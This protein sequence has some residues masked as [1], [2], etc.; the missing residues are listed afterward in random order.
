MPSDKVL[1][2]SGQELD[3]MICQKRVVFEMVIDLVQFASDEVSLER[4]RDWIELGDAV[5]FADVLRVKD[6]VVELGFA[7][8]FDPA[9]DPIL[10]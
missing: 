1:G 4:E 7:P 2:Q 9:V 5:C 8:G 3:E 10:F 6:R